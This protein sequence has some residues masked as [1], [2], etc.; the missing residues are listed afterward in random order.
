MPVKKRDCDG[1]LGA[2]LRL[3]ACRDVGTVGSLPQQAGCRE[4]SIRLD[5]RQV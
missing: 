2:D 5:L 4:S 1:M 3:P